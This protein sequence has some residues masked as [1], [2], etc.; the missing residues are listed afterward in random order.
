MSTADA[1]SGNT[2]GGAPDDAALPGAALLQQPRRL[3]EVLSPLLT[4]WLDPGTVV[5]VSSR[6]GTSPRARR[7]HTSSTG[8][9]MSRITTSGA[10]HRACSSPSAP[11]YATSTR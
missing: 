8:I 10:Q 11:L 9:R 4:G 5:R 7:R 3:V 2:P 1:R 6:I